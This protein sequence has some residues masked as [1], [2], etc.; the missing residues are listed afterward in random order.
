MQQIINSIFRITTPITAFLIMILNLLDDSREG[1]STESLNN[2]HHNIQGQQESKTEKKAF[3]IKLPNI[4][5]FFASCCIAIIAFWEK[6][7]WISIVYYF[8]VIIGSITIIY[9]CF[10]KKEHNLS[11][12]EM[13]ALTSLFSYC[14]AANVVKYPILETNSTSTLT[15]EAL[16]VMRMSFG[17]FFFLFYMLTVLL[18]VQVLLLRRFPPKKIKYISFDKQS[19]SDTHSKIEKN[20]SKDKSLHVWHCFYALVYLFDLIR[21]LIVLIIKVGISFINSCIAFTNLVLFKIVERIYLRTDTIIIR[22]CFNIAL[23]TSLSL[24]YTIIVLDG[25]FSEKIR[26]LFS[27]FSTVIIIPILITAIE[28]IRNKEESKSKQE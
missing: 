19:I 6:I 24:V 18:M 28:K 27:F 7:K 12:N 16:Q 20:K 3:R 4:I 5:L 9:H 23:I 22:I 13:T 15:V 14:I 10:G 11:E 26:D 21:D 17:Y 25:G 1:I 8:G 2:S